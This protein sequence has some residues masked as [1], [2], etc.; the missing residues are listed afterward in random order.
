MN[1]SER[2]KLLD[3]LRSEKITR[4]R[5]FSSLTIPSLM[6]PE[7]WTE[8]NSLP[9]PFSS[10]SARGVTSMA[11]RML[12]ALL[13]LNDMPF[14]RFELTTGAEPDPDIHSYLEVLSYQVFNRLSS[15]NLREI[16]YQAL[17]NLIVSGDCLLIM[18]DDFNFRLIRLD[19]YVCRRDVYGGLEELIYVEYQSLP[20]DDDSLVNQ[21]VSLSVTEKK[22]YRKIFV[23]SVKNEEG[24]WEVEKQD[25][26]GVVVD[27]GE[28][29]VLPYITLRWSGIP[30]ENYGRSHVEDLIGDIK[31]LEAF[32][33][34]LIYGVT[35]SSLFWMACDPAGMTEL[36]DIT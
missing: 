2:Y 32:T 1:I 29:K 24:L 9:Q 36:D 34:A 28:F 18:E 14:F 26:E 11:S 20:V 31:A 8:Q 12:S 19:R 27:R 4:V 22:G 30:G 5:Y 33:E 25:E 10:T 6:P 23:R 7:G 21:M 3:S 35:A 13:P 16:V 15:G 17:Q